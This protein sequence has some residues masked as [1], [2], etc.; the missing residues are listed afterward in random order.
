MNNVPKELK[1]E[2]VKI[3]D[4]VINIYNMKELFRNMENKSRFTETIE[5]QSNE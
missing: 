3:V 2:I 5:E 1:I 4:K